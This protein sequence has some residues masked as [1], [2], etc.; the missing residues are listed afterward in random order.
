MNLRF[1]LTKE[2]ALAIQAEQVAHYA[3]YDP[4]IAAKVAAVTNADALLPGVEY[5]VVEVNRHIPRGGFIEFLMG[6][7]KPAH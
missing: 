5:D 1:R 6:Q 7:A 2:R 3:Q 4:D